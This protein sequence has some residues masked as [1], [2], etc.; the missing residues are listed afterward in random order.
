MKWIIKKGDTVKV[1]T[2]D[3]KGKQGRVSEII[4]D[5]NRVIV[6]GVN[7][8][9]RHTKP[10]AQ[11]PQGGL[12]KTEGGIHVSNVALLS[13]GAATR[14]GRKE[15]KGVTVRYAKKTGKLID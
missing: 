12:V 1:L 13:D 5:K 10:N 3:D 9:T 8:N 2:G 7:I 14:A 11:S 15:V 4:K 6:E